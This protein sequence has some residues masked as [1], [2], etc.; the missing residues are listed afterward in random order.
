MLDQI[1]LASHKVDPNSSCDGLYTVD[2]IR[3][4]VPFTL[5]DNMGHY[6]LSAVASADAAQLADEAAAAVAVANCA[7]AAAQANEAAAAA[8]GADS[9]AYEAAIA[10]TLRA[11]EAADVAATHARLAVNERDAMR[12]GVDWAAAREESEGRDRMHLNGRLA[13]A[14]GSMEASE[15]L[16]RHGSRLSTEDRADLVQLMSEQQQRRVHAEPPEPPNAGAIYVAAL[17]RQMLRECK[18]LGFFAGCVG[19]QRLRDA[20]LAEAMSAAKVDLELKRASYS[21]EEN[22]VAAFF[23]NGQLSELSV[24]AG[25]GLLQAL[26]ENANSSN[27]GASNEAGDGKAGS[28]NQASQQKLANAPDLLLRVQRAVAAA[29]RSKLL[30]ASA[31]LGIRPCAEDLAK[32]GS[33]AGLYVLLIPDKGQKIGDA[34]RNV[35]IRAS[36]QAN[37][38]EHVQFANALSWLEGCGATKLDPARSSYLIMEGA[39]TRSILGWGGRGQGNEWYGS[40]KTQTGQD[41]SRGGKTSRW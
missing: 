6:N 15:L 25:Q 38:G 35:E 2:A 11:K 29:E 13:T 37:A 20:N 41:P 5:L 40:V 7:L 28:G 31:A 8:A 36:S 21:L 34:K 30:E 10:A 32:H 23:I 16:L 26:A 4:S 33:N 17:H 1:S 12:A 9:S 27:V 39:E 3:T 19:R 18:E 24:K 14:H 22:T